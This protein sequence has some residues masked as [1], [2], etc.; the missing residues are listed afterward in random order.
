VAPDLTNVPVSGWRGLICQGPL[1]GERGALI[2]TQQ[3]GE[4][5][6]IG[7]DAPCL[8]LCHQLRS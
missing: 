6:N 2:L 5:S 3:V 4:L 8:V 7:G 1:S